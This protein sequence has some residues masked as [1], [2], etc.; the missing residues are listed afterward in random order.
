[1]AKNVDKKESNSEIRH[2][3]MADIAA[4]VGVSRQLVGLVFRGEPGV[5]AAT[6]AKIQGRG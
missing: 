1:M 4:E 2:A 5:G 3:T 6:E